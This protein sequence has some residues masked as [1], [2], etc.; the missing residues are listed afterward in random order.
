[1]VIPA[2]HDLLN[3]KLVGDNKSSTQVF[4]PMDDGLSHAM[5]AMMAIMINTDN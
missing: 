4:F 3:E 1:M 2:I 5:M